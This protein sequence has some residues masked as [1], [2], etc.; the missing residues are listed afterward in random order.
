MVVV[1]VVVGGGK[2]G[3]RERAGGGERRGVLGISGSRRA[4]SMIQ[5]GRRARL[6]SY[7]EHKAP[8]RYIGD[9]APPTSH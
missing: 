4:C 9:H 3:R 7:P 6:A 1:V 2:K 5:S 8:A